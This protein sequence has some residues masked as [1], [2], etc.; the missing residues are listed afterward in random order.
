MARTEIQ[1]RTVW[2]TGASSGIGRALATVLA[3]R[4][5][6]LIL[7]SRNKQHLTDLA[8]SL[9]CPVTVMD[10]DISK[11]SVTDLLRA[12]F[13]KLESGL[14][15]VILCAGD[16]EYVNTQH[17]D[18]AVIERMFNVNV[19]GLSRSIQAALPALRKS[20][21]SPYL[22]GIS[23]ASAI[24][25][26][27]RAEAY[28]A[29]KAAVVSLLESLA[30]DLFQEGIRVTTVLPGFVDTP[31]TQRNDFPMP[32]LMSSEQAAKIIVDGIEADKRCIE[33]PKQLTWTLRFMS[34]LPEKIRL[35]IGQRMVRQ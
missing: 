32:F 33:F 15:L 25:G 19:F 24:T 23:S 35:K 30:L 6:H 13:D 22:V 3:E 27:P 10:A 5:N 29:S 18:T 7:T 31:L 1:N 21:H 17:F 34:L 2:I 8:D 4:G 12:E 11:A 20:R 26:L 9:N 28:G 14:D 16:C